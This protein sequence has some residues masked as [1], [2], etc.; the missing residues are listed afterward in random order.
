M[1]A[2]LTALHHQLSGKGPV[3]ALPL[4]VVRIDL[5]SLLKAGAAFVGTALGAQELELEFFEVRMGYRHLTF[6]SHQSRK[7]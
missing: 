6:L 5:G 4:A 2:N 3:E 1:A 7:A